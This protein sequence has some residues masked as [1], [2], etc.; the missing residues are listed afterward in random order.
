MDK[1]LSQEILST[2]SLCEE[3]IF[4]KIGAEISSGQ[5]AFPPGKQD[6]IKIGKRW[7]THN[8]ERLVTNVCRSEV[9]KSVLE[10]GDEL[11]LVSAILDLIC[12]IVTGVS[13]ATVAV[14]IV[15]LGLEKVCESIW[16]K[17]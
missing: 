16:N 17:K 9:I 4:E 6:I 14:L 15:K 1:I 13:P 5:D 3:E 12:G 10:S 8:R 11:A 2:L 7:W